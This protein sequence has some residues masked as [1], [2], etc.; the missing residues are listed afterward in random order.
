MEIASI[1]RCI[2]RAVSFYL[3]S[4]STLV[5]NLTLP[6]FFP[7][8][9]FLIG[10]T[11]CEIFGS[12]APSLGWLVTQLQAKQAPHQPR[13]QSS[14]VQLRGKLQLPFCWILDPEQLVVK[15]P[16]S[17]NH[18]SVE[19]YPDYIHEKKLKYWRLEGPI[20]HFDDR[21]RKSK[22]TCTQ[23]SFIEWFFVFI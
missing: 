10:K 21:W 8:G 3:V 13:H 23:K 12:T 22:Q 7:L 20:F 2:Y 15:E 9:D 18:G 1:P 6:G 19:D 16:V 4:I 5:V 17:H 11:T 14:V